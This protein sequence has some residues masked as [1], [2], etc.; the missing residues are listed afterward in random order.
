M[1]LVG[2]VFPSPQ[3]SFISP[4]NAKLWSHSSVLDG[5][6]QRFIFGSSLISVQW[7]VQGSLT[8]TGRN[9]PFSYVIRIHSF[10]GHLCTRTWGKHTY[11]PWPWTR[12][13]VISTS[14]SEVFMWPVMMVK[15]KE[16]IEMSLIK[17]LSQAL[18]VILTETAS[19]P[20]WLNSLNENNPCPP[21]PTPLPGEDRCQQWPHMLSFTCHL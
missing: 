9:G 16:G 15:G 2:R 11:P 19:L 3:G 17:F 5:L 20:H 4:S 6:T 8:S 1:E 14:V 10:Q 21:H 13:D 7:F 18:H 12:S